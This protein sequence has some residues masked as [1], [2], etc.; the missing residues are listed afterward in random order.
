MLGPNSALN[1]NTTNNNNNKK[2]CREELFVI[3]WYNVLDADVDQHLSAK[4]QN[5]CCVWSS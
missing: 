5:F 3:M 4:Q 2:G 1:I